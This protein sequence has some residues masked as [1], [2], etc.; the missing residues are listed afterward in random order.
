VTPAIIACLVLGAWIAG[1]G[2][3]AWAQEF[4]APGPGA[5][6]RPERRPDNPRSPVDPAPP[7]P[8]GESEDD[9]ERDDAAPQP[10]S[11]WDQPSGEYADSAADR[12]GAWGQGL[13]SVD[14]DQLNP[15]RYLHEG[16]E[17]GS[18]TLNGVL[19]D[20]IK[21]LDPDADSTIEVFGRFRFRRS[22]INNATDFN[23]DAHDY[24]IA[25][26]DAWEAG[27]IFRME[28]MRLDASAQHVNGRLVD[29]MEDH[30]DLGRLSLRITGFDGRPLRIEAPGET[31]L[32]LSGYIGRG[33]LILGRGRLIG[34]DDWDFTGQHFDAI[35]LT[36]TDAD[37]GSGLSLFVMQPVLHRPFRFN[38][39]MRGH[40]LFGAALLGLDPFNQLSNADDQ[41]ERALLR[42][43]DRDTAM[44]P[45]AV[46]MPR[47]RR[48]AAGFDLYGIWYYV[49]SDAQ[50]PGEPDANTGEVETGAIS[51]L[52]A[53]ARGGIRYESVL[54]LEGEFTFQ[55]GE[56]GGDPMTA[57]GVH[58]ELTVAVD[59]F[60]QLSATFLFDWATGDADPTDGTIETFDPLFPI[61]HDRFGVLDLFAFQNLIHYGVHVR[62]QIGNELVLAGGLHWLQSATESDAVYGPG[63]WQVLLAPDPSLNES[64]ELGIIVDAGIEYHYSARVHLIAGFGQ[65]IPGARF[66]RRGLDDAAFIFWGA[67]EIRF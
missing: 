3:P 44:V 65:F 2:S 1:G 5:A 42:P 37:L 23:S 35:V 56:R 46:P 26:R 8:A 66:T 59:T 45:V 12:R 15:L 61:Q 54:M 49:N 30:W 57:F 10:P 22:E 13:R 16:L 55:I 58:G 4:D 17:W 31:W 29:D 33:P 38:K 51:L 64:R 11:Y 24:E 47:E 40:H 53:G 63:P 25:W 67:T 60:V 21:E 62:M 6:D 34:S 52:S 9:D 14:I 39:A 27:A 7:A 19:N 32:Q 18:R 50:V 28:D 41:F 43:A 20:L 36:I 48:L